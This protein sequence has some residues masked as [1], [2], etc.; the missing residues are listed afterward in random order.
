MSTQQNHYP[1]PRQDNEFGM[2]VTRWNRTYPVGPY[3]FINRE[4]FIVVYKTNLQIGG[5]WDALWDRLN[6]A[7][8][9]RI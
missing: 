4:Y 7:S 6:R 9:L 8:S 1:S 2:P 5:I 3:R